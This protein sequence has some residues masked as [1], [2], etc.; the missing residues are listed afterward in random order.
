MG[1]VWKRR[2]IR[3]NSK[4]SPDT[5]TMTTSRPGGQSS[6]TRHSNG[7]Q[8]VVIDESP[9]A[10]LRD[11]LP[12]SMCEAQASLDEAEAPLVG[13][14]NAVSPQMASLSDAVLDNF[15]AEAT[16]LG[17]LFGFR[18]RALRSSW[19]LSQ[20]QV[21]PVIATIIATQ[22]LSL[23][24]LIRDTSSSEAGSPVK[25]PPVLPAAPATAASVSASTPEAA[26]MS[27]AA[28]ATAPVDA[29]AV[30]ELQPAGC[31][32]DQLA[33]FSPAPATATAA[34]G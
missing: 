29:K 9:V 27:M 10:N 3:G 4:S 32:L 6:A 33:L 17:R 34:G 15:R 23:S 20:R 25:A 30:Y 11:D 7:R 1:E 5:D 12:S 19:A 13:R 24:P 26:I 28:M 14:H 2:N 8:L 16:K 31:M 21:I 22:T 18:A